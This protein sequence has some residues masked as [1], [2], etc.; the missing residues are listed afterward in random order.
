MSFLNAVILAVLV[1]T[2]VSG[3]STCGQGG[4]TCIGLPTGCA[5]KS[6]ASCEVLA[7]VSVTGDSVHV[8]LTSTA[9][10]TLKLNLA[11]RWIG[12]GFSEDGQMGKSPVVHCFS[13]GTQAQ[14]K[15]TYNSDLGYF[16]QGWTG[17]DQ[18]QLTTKT[19]SANAV[20]LACSVNIKRKLTIKEFTFDLVGTKHSLIVATGPLVAGA[21]KMHDI[22]PETSFP[23]AY[24]F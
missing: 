3:Q 19:S 2:L 8:D 14:S 20:T 11:N 5:A 4:I 17:I 22:A 13:D 6:E 18:T 7:K 23:D 21:I 12:V 10:G 1:S 15:L 24:S 16:N 9:A